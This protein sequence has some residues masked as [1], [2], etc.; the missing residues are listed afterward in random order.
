MPTR[1]RR[2]GVVLNPELDGALRVAADRLHADSEAARV[3]ELALIGARALGAQDEALVELDRTLVE[4]GATRATGD[5][6]AIS[7]RLLA[8]SHEG[9]R[10]DE[11]PSE[12]LDWVRGRPGVD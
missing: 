10:A 3:R 1:Y 7:R 2:V 9:E 4:L 6:I 5:L 12:S 8:E 11:T